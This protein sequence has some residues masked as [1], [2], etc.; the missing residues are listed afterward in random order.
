MGTLDKG[1]SGE[2]R[3]RAHLESKGYRLLKANYRTRLGE[4]DLVMEHQG[5]VVFVEVKT[6]GNAAFGRPQ[7]S[8]NASKQ[9]R[10]LKAA[11]EFIKEE[12]LSGR[13]FRFDV[14]S[15]SPEG[16]EHLPNAFGA[17]AGRYTI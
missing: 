5:A 17:P 10:I 15:V 13:P 7:E 6:R 14:V 11:L 16:I 9:R 4:L 1:H 8:V 3:A 12:R 2:E